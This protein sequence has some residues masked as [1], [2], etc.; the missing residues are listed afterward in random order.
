[1]RLAVLKMT[2]STV[3][4]TSGIMCGTTS[5]LLPVLCNPAD[6]YVGWHFART[7]MRSIA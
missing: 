2:T 4:S 1:L 5:C 3:P 6:Q 7:A